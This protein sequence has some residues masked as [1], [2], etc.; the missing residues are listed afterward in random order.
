MIRRRLV[1]LALVIGGF[2]GMAAVPLATPASAS[3]TQIVSPVRTGLVG[4]CI[5]VSQADQGV[6]IHL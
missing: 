4:V 6:C 5:I 2:V 3:V 1:M